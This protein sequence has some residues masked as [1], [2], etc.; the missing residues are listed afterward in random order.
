MINAKPKYINKRKKTSAIVGSEKNRNGFKK[1]RFIC[2]LSR[3]QLLFALAFALRLKLVVNG[4]FC[5]FCSFSL[6]VPN[7]LQSTVNASWQLNV[8][9][10]PYSDEDIPRSPWAVVPLAL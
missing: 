3:A 1:N 2:Q 5:I 7:H 10:P 4:V 6:V 9:T 8:T